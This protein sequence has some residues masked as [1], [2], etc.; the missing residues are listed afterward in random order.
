MSTELELLPPPE[1]HQNLPLIGAGKRRTGARVPPEVVERIL[2]MRAA[3][4]SVEAVR[5]ETGCDT[6]TILVIE[7]QAR[8][9]GILPQMKEELLALTEDVA[10]LAGGEL[11]S[12]LMKHPEKVPVNVLPVAMGVALDKRAVL[13]AEPE[14]TTAET[15]VDPLARL[16]EA[17]LR[18]YEAPKP[19]PAQESANPAPTE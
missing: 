2:E 4:A 6:R 14:P 5:R 11:L 8:D 10:R 1:P 17:Y 16:K 3:G 18:L 13:Q 19:A 9:A 7:R 15:P 12:R